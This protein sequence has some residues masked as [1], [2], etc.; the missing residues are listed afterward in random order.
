MNN[1]NLINKISAKFSLSKKN[2]ELIFNKIFEGIKTSLKEQKE[3]EIENFGNFKV[4]RRKMQKMIDYNKKAVVLLPPKDKLVFIYYNNTKE[5][6]NQKEYKKKELQAKQLIKEIAGEYNL[7]EIEVY[8]FYY[9]LFDIINKCFSKNINVNILGFGKFKIT[10]KGKISFSPAKKFQDDINYNFNNLDT[11]V[12]R[13]L[14]AAELSAIKSPAKEAEFIEKSEEKKYSL[15]DTIVIDTDVDKVISET[16]AD[17]EKEIIEEDKLVESTTEEPVVEEKVDRITNKYEE[18]KLRLQEEIADLKQRIEKLET[19]EKVKE[20]IEKEIEIPGEETLD[21]YEN[22]IGIEKEIS[23]LEDK[24]KEPETLIEE[25]SEE[26]ILDQQIYK[27]EKK[28]IIP[29][30]ETEREKEFTEEVLGK[31]YEITTTAEEKIFSREP[32]IREEK[33][34]GYIEQ[35]EPFVEKK[36]ES[37]EESFERKWQEIREK[38][39]STTPDEIEELKPPSLEKLSEVSLEPPTIPEDRK[40]ETI[41]KEEEVKP[42]IQFKETIVEE[43]TIKVEKPVIGV[44]EVIEEVQEKDFSSVYPEVVED[45]DALSISEIYNRMKESFSYITMEQKQDINEETEIFREEEKPRLIQEIKEDSIET[46]SIL[47][48]GPEKLVK[49][50]PTEIVDTSMEDVIKKYER[51]REKLKEQL[52]KDE[53]SYPDEMKR[54]KPIIPVEAP[55][56][57][58]IETEIE[59]LE[60][61]IEPENIIKD[62][63]KTYIYEEKQE[64]PIN[65]SKPLTS[66][67]DLEERK[68]Q[69]ELTESIDKTLKEIKSYMDEIARK[70]KLPL[71]NSENDVEKEIPFKALNE[72]ELPKSID[73]YFE[74]ITQDNIKKFPNLNGNSTNN[75]E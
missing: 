2:C 24:I 43:P 49:E 68:V 57:N 10:G 50:E 61:I 34:E 73:D 39:F 62:T 18:E 66:I 28:D 46:S 31:E 30:F 32:E 41:T 13:T 37:W 1:I 38:I 7:N 25:E 64:Q 42:E 12:I 27:E 53:I 21:G 29:S 8:N 59:N 72:I 56:E 71:S 15:T 6:E 36:E 75:K 70:E 69:D 3:F 20:I 52:M 65:E 9:T 16:L 51:L 22:E 35:K 19:E 11:I 17:F 55:I 45:E 74:K 44:Q 4:I 14:N 5:S 33:K 54:E 47:P 26:F 23:E 67:N 40:F 48:E 58:I 63:S 60:E